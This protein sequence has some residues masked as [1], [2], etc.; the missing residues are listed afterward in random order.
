MPPGTVDPFHI[1]NALPSAV[2][3]VRPDDSFAFANPAAE[4]MF[5]TSAAQLCQMR[6]DELFGFGSAVSALIRQ[7]REDMAPMA[8]FDL[9]ISTARTSHDR[10]SVAAA[11]VSPDGT[12]TRESDMIVQ[13]S[14]ISIAQQIEQ[15]MRRQGAARS[16]AG[17]VSVLAHEV[18]NPLAGIK[19]AAQIIEGSVDGDD[20]A[21]TRLIADEVDRIGNLIRRIDVFA[22]IGPAPGAAVNIHEALDR[23][24]RVLESSGA[25]DGVNI[26]DAFDPSLPDV[27]GDFEGLVQV[28][29]NLIK[30]ALD[31]AAEGGGEVRLGTAY[32]H[33]IRLAHD[34]GGD[35]GGLP[36][37]VTIRD[38][39]PGIPDDLQSDVFDPFVSTK[40]DGHGLGL[41]VVAKIIGDH[42]GVVTFESEP[43]RT[44]FVVRLPLYGG[45]EKTT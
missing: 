26:I 16:A 9:P 23:A 38:N 5:K 33:G 19:G 17:M 22:D 39:G 8:D 14:P 3:A 43:R 11:Q 36:I 45:M 4:A 31:A 21:L 32:R 13:F 34:V 28:F 24:R 42:G 40:A 44:I 37:E 10:V 1:L 12:V 6:L 7:S 15:Q 2:L 35:S 18:R 25:S 29:I 20:R 27:R 41:A 30:N